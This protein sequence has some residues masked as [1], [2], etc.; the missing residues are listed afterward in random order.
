MFAIIRMST[1][2]SVVVTYNATY[3]Y[4]ETL[5]INPQLHSIDGG[6][7]YVTSNMQIP[8]NIVHRQ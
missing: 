6:V 5:D 1:T 8:E 7:L 4:P 3:G 2:G